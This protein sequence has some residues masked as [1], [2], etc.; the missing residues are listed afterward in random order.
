MPEGRNS[1]L[2][3]QYRDASNYKAGRTVV[4]AGRLTDEELRALRANREDGMFFI[5]SQVGLPDLQDTWG[6]RLYEDDHVWHELEDDA[7][8]PTDAAPTEPGDV[9]QFASAFASAVWDVPAAA[10]RIGLAV[11]D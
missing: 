2:W 5:P 3:Y 1:S 10:A 6:G 8:Q 7:F 9:H 11:D 4:F